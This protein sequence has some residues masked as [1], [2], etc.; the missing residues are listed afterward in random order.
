M[1]LKFDGCTPVLRAGLDEILPELNMAEPDSDFT[2]HLESIE[3]GLS[4]SRNGS[5]INIA[6]NRRSEF[7]RA[8]GLL[9]QGEF[10]S[11]TPAFET[12]GVMLDCSRNAVMNLNGLKKLI[13]MIALMGFNTLMLYTEDTYE[14]PGQPYFGYMR[15]RYT[16]EE[17]HEIDRYADLF[18]IEVVPCIQTLAHL[19]AI[20]R[21]YTYAAD[22]F[23]CDDILMADEEKTYR[24]I[25]E[26]ISSM[27][28]SLKSRKIHIG[29]DEAH[30]LGLGKHLDRYGY[31]NR[32]EILLRH[33][34][35]V[36]QICEKYGYQPMIWSDMY[37]KLLS[38]T[39]DYYDT[40][41]KVTDEIRNMIP[42]GLNLVYWDYD[43]MDRDTYEKMLDLHFQLSKNISFAGGAWKWTGF[44]PQMQRSFVTSRAALA[45]CADKNVKNVYVTAW[46]DNGGACQTFTILPTLQLYAEQC[47]ER[48]MEYAHVEKR[49]AA[50][51]NADLNDFMQLDLPNLPPDGKWR[52][53][54]GNPAD[55]MFYQDILCGLFD[56]HVQKG[57]ADYF[58]KAA[59]M[60]YT[61]AQKGGQWTYIYNNIANLCS[62][63]SL[64]SEMGIRLKEAYDKKD[65]R[66]LSEIAYQELPEL[67]KRVKG[68][69]E[70]LR[71]AW[72]KENKPFGMDV[73]DIRIGGVMARIDS[74]VLTLTDYLTGKIPVIEEL[75]QERLFYDCRTE[76]DRVPVTI[77]RNRWADIVSAGVI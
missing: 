13:R 31:Q 15:G 56:R 11:E 29:M 12:L 62:V 16:R 55:Y 52:K 42:D 77:C 43:H 51:A 70:S 76:V 25:E 32:F 41:V 23:D 48:N 21:W 59:E 30:M 5:R 22:I 36:V 6:F 24:L 61:V 53:E 33:Q 39:A 10:V 26:M 20:K 7:Y 54:L 60:L 72:M 57:S 67:S 75:E 27:A 2:V 17:L 73:E 28:S 66:V 69:H 8:L 71:T 47:Y 64:K 50:C 40:S 63:L 44:V 46:G 18:G 19:N 9:K 3:K 74:A 35:R 1:S 4:L 65:N 49:L 45:A 34:K 37:F 14:I 58:R 38:H 68:F